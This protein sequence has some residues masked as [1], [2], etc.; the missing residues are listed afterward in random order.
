MW[1]SEWWEESQNTVR[2]QRVR[3]V[4]RESVGQLAAEGPYGPSA[5]L[6]PSTV[7]PGVIT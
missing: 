7:T 3:L 1:S 6:K 2:N 5:D 4:H